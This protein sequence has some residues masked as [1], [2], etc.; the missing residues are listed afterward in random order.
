MLAMVQQDLE[1]TAPELS[2]S[3]WCSS[4]AASRSDSTTSCPSEDRE[5]ELTSRGGTLLLETAL[6]SRPLVVLRQPRP[7][8]KRDQRKRPEPPP[9]A[10]RS[11]SPR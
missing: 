5:Q 6:L 8:C 10:V 7:S 4:S 11:Q 1:L 2:F 9:T 3:S